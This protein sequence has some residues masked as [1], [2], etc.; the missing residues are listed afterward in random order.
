M[1]S[2]ALAQIAAAGHVEVYGTARVDVIADD[3]PTND[4]QKPFFVL[5]EPEEPNEAFRDGQLTIHPRLTRLGVNLRGGGR[6]RGNVEV[7]F[8][9]GGSESRALPRVRHAYL[10]LHFAGVPAIGGDWYVLGGQTWD[11]IAPLVPAANGDTLLWNAGNLGDRRPQLRFTYVRGWLSAALALVQTGAV[12]GRDQDRP[13][14]AAPGT[15]TVPDGVD[16]ARPGGQARLGGQGRRARVGLWAH[17]GRT[18]STAYADDGVE[19]ARAAGLDFEFQPHRRLGLRGEA[20]WGADLADVR[21]GI[22][23]GLTDDGHMVE[24]RGGWLEA[25]VKVRPRWTVTPGISMDDAVD[26]HVDGRSFG[27]GAP[28]SLNRVLYLANRWDLGGGVALGADYLMW[29]T[30]YAKDVAGAATPNGLDN[31]F[32]VWLAFTP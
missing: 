18:A 2:L 28:R 7:D 26:E 6:A 8:Q 23:Q 22:G 15:I 13:R 32:N 17:L 1:L 20:F 27:G 31:R 5:P 29:A 3:S 25:P 14:D 9:N 24:A 30:V 19:L 4:T 11:V 21:G 10:E 16:A 12:D